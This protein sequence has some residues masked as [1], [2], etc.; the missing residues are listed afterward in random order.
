MNISISPFSPR[1]NPDQK[2]HNLLEGKQ[3]M[4]KLIDFGCSID[5]RQFPSGTTF[6]ASVDTSGFQC[7]EMKT[8]RPWTYQVNLWIVFHWFY[9]FILFVSRRICLVR[10]A[11]CT[12]WYL[13]NTWTS[14]STVPR[15]HGSNPEC[16]KGRLYK[17]MFVAFIYI[18]CNYFRFWPGVETWKSLFADFMN[19]PSCDQLPDLT[20]YRSRLEEIVRSCN[21]SS[22]Q[23]NALME[24]LE[25]ALIRI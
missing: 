16:S 17:F 22:V 7:I 6:S 25:K 14:Y 8:N 15:K 13:E 10:S 9:H 2:L 1:L 21:L 23:F 12:C 19:V 24:R 11:H 20:K 18:V 3:K 4:L 5:M